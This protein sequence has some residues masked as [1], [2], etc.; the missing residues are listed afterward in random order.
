MAEPQLD[1]ARSQSHPSPL[2]ASNAA[3]I[4]NPTD[5]DDDDDEVSKIKPTHHIH[6]TTERKI[7]NKK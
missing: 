3:V 7:K 5:L 1:V 4:I 2:I 6:R